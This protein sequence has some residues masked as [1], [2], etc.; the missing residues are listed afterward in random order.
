MDVLDG[1]KEEVQKIIKDILQT[2]TTSYVKHYALGLVK[3]IE[4]DASKEPGP[5]W[6]LTPRPDS[7]AEPLKA[8]N[9]IKKKEL[10]TRLGKNVGSSLDPIT[11][12]STTKLKVKRK[13]RKLNRKE[14][15]FWRV[16]KWLP[17][18]TMVPYKRSRNWLPN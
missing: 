3:K 13:P 6:K 1:V 7:N 17:I 2:F 11:W 12:S 14:R 15:F 16:I 8:G 4:D 18:P 5:D 10:S 9:L